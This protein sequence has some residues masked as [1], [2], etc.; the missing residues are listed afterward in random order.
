MKNIDYFGI[1]LAVPDDT[2]FVAMDGKNHAYAVRAYTEDAN[3]LQWSADTKQWVYDN[4]S[5]EY[6]LIPISD[7][8]LLEL[9]NKAKPKDSLFITN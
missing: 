8:A 1:M 7:S 9:R 3:S 4:S 2:M 6:T 5:F